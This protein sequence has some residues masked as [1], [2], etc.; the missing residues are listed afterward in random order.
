M[1]PPKTVQEIFEA[2]KIEEV[3]ED[4]VQLKR[5]GVNMLGLCP[6]HHEKTPS[7]TVSPTKNIF[8]CFGCGKGGNAVQFL[9]EHENFS[10]PDALRF[11]ARKYG[12]KIEER[13]LTQ[14]EREARQYEDSLFIVN[15]FAKEYYQQ[16]LFHTERGKSIGLSYFKERGFLESTL[17]NFELGFALNEKDRFTLSAVNKGYNIDL[18]RKVGLTTQYDRD[19]FRDRVIFPIHSLSGKV[20]AFAGRM[21]ATNV[22][23][24]KYINSPETDIYVKNKILYG[25]YFAKKA[26]RQKDACILVEGY[27]DVISLFQ[28]GIENV[29]ASSGTSLTVGQIR[30]I[31]RY[32]PNITILYDGDPAGIKAALRGLDLILEQDMNVKIVLLPEEE[33]PDSYLKQVGVTAFEEYMLQNAKDFILFKTS[34]LLKEI[35]DDPV[36]K[37]DVI[38]DLVASIAKIPD[39]VKRSLYT[40]ECSKEVGVEEEILVREVNKLVSRNLRNRRFKKKTEEKRPFVEDTGFPEQEFRPDGIGED[41][42]ADSKS[43]HEFQEKHVIGLLIAYG[44]KLFDPEEDMMVAEYILSNVEEL[45]DEFDNKLYAQVAKEYRQRLL[46]KEKTNMQYFINH[47]DEKIR[48]LSVN[49]ISSPFEYSPNWE[50]KWQI[51]LQT[52]KMPDE[53]FIKD[54][55]QSILRFKL[56]KIEKMYAANAELVKNAY[57][58]K[59]DKDLLLYLKTQQRLQEIRKEFTESLKM[60]VLRYS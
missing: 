50:K 26:I 10:F 4:F 16:N 18:L 33:D 3:V 7:F 25:A 19:F 31:K 46:E 41:K 60:V 28:A 1:I 5:R 40:K 44:D 17:K 53:N 51:N 43:T 52:Q 20:V 2:A 58:E 56:K 32:T 21:L 39:P 54:S 8:K 34:L 45:L 22:K 24:P 37:T 55:K 27:T 35:G 47:S 23:A 11:L 6:F 36:R 30:L 29:V 48:K 38:R 9:M 15:Q 49:L 59:N 12:I 14:E 57:E 42:S 13:E